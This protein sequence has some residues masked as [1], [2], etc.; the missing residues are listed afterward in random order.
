MLIYHQQYLLG[1]SA[2]KPKFKCNKEELEIPRKALVPNDS[3][4][5]QWNAS[6]GI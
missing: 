3:W 6:R 2:V 4:S 1:V 5:E